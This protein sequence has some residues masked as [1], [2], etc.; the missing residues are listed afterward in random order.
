MIPTYD[1]RVADERRLLAALFLY[2]RA[3]ELEA[4]HFL[5]PDH[6]LLFDCVEQAFAIAPWPAANRHCYDDIALE[7][8][9]ECV[10]QRGRELDHALDRFPERAAQLAAW[11]RGYIVDVLMAQA[12]TAHAIDDLV[13]IVRVCPR[14]GR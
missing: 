5:A 9:V 2:P 4:R 13:E 1:Q 14:C 3:V 11:A 12:V 6:G 7:V 8:V 10:R